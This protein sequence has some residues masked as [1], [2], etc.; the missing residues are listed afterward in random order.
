MSK[1]FKNERTTNKVRWARR[2]ER[3][4]K[5]CERELTADEQAEL[6]AWAVDTF[7]EDSDRYDH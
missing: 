5:S 7:G 4:T 6:N 3:A 2:A 1:T